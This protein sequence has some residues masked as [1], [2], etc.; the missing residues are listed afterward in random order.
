VGGREGSLTRGEKGKRVIHW[1]PLHVAVIQHEQSQMIC[2][3]AST[4]FEELGASLISSYN[5]FKKENTSKAFS[6]HSGLILGLFCDLNWNLNYD[7]FT[8]CL[9]SFQA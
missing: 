9:P 3:S 5:T 8:E 2:R 4:V 1:L 7:T 6:E